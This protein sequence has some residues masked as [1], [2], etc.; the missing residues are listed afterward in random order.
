MP[1]IEYR[2]MF[3]MQMTEAFFVRTEPAS[4]IV[5]PAHIHMMNAPQTRKA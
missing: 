2:P 1:A 3:F 4:S 5:K